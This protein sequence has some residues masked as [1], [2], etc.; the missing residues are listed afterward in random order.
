MS[1]PVEGLD[2]LQRGAWRSDGGFQSDIQKGCCNRGARK[3]WLFVGLAVAAAGAAVLITGAFVGWYKSSSSSSAST[4]SSLPAVKPPVAAAAPSGLGGNRTALS[5][6]GGARPRLQALNPNDVKDRF[7]NAAGG[8]TELWALLDGVDGRTREVNERI[9]QFEACYARHGAVPPLPYTIRVWSANETM[10]A[11][12]K[13]VWSATGNIT[14]VTGFI[15]FGR[16]NDTFYLYEY[17]G[18]TAMASRVTLAP[19]PSYNTSTTNVSALVAAFGAGATAGADA[20]VDQ[21]ELWY[22]V[23]MLN[24]NGSHAVVHVLARPRVP[25]FEMAAAGAGIGF[26]GAQLRGT[27]A[28]MFVTG[29]VDGPACAA[30]DTVCTLANDTSVTTTCDADVTEFELVPLGRV[31]YT[32]HNASQYPG[33]GANNVHLTVLGTDDDTYFGPVV[34]L[35]GLA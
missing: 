33:G 16:V 2:L 3:V 1:D 11:T 34:P 8:P 26:C 25:V 30:T 20:V 13:D 15:M 23:G 28:T 21:V 5:S 10:Y 18:E 12:C 29:S 32:G 24:T 9:D 35:E 14:N 17:G 4:T 22:S 6:S 31:E 7:F 19:G 27:N